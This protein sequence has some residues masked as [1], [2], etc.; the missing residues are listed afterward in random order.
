MNKKSLNLITETNYKEKFLRKFIKNKNKSDTKDTNKNTNYNNLKFKNKNIPPKKEDILLAKSKTLFNMNKIFFNI[1]QYNSKEKDYFIN[2]SQLIDILRHGNI[3]NP[4]II[5]INQTDIIL[6]KIFPHKTKFNFTEFMN[7][8]TELCHELYKDK[9]EKFPKDTM[10]NFL[11]CLYN[12]YKE[13]IIE[14][15]MTNFMETIEDNNCT[16]KSIETIISSKLERP[17]IKLILTLYDNLVEVYRVY[18]PNELVKYKSIN[19][20]RLFSESSQNLFKFCKD[21]ELYP[22]IINK[23]NLTMYYNLLMKYLKQKSYINM[24]IISFAENRKCKNLGICFKFSSFVL[25]LYHLCIFDYYKGLKFQT[26]GNCSTNESIQ[27]DESLIDV[28]KIVYFFKQ[29]ENSTGIKQFLLERARTNEKKYNFIFKK[30]DINI[31]KK[32]MDIPCNDNNEDEKKF[33]TINSLN[34]D[35]VYKILKLNKKTIESSPYTSVQLSERKIETEI[36]DEKNNSLLLTNA[37]NIFNNNN[38]NKYFL[39]MNKKDNY[40][41]SLSDLDEVLSVSSV[42]KEE[43]INK[44]EKLSEIF[45]RYSK[46][47]SKLEYNRMSYSSFLKFLSDAKLL[48]KVPTKNKIKYRRISSNLMVKTYTVAGIKQFER[49]LKYSISCDNIVLT[50]EEIKYKKYISKLVDTFRSTKINNKDKIKMT[51][52]S[53]I[54]STVT[55]S[56]NYPSYFSGI[57]KQLNIKDEFYYKYMNDFI[58][59]TD[60]FEPKKNANEEKYIP[61]K[62]NFA[63]FIKSFE[64]IASKLYPKILLDDAVSTFLTLKIDPFIIRIRKHTYKNT[65]IQKAMDKMEK[66]EIEKVLGKLGNIIYPFFIKFADNNKQMLFYQFF[67]VY[68]NLG[69][70][71][72]MISLTQM[73]K[74]FY[75][76]CDNNLDD[77]S[78]LQKDK[79]MNDKITFD[80]FIIS[81][82]IS[83]MLFNFSNIVSDTDRILYIYYFILESKFFK[84]INAKKNITKKIYKNL[85]FRNDRK[86]RQNSSVEISTNRKMRLNYDYKANKYKC[87]RK[88]IKRYN[89]FD[90]Y[91]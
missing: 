63:L 3:I 2:K 55:G 7:Y 4:E 86:L 46:I 34:N 74:I 17:I 36:N 31:A 58:R 82:G 87:D 72:E 78:T 13:I 75:I 61:N 20:V 81:L 62:M 41:I 18:F 53:L 9:F 16:L 23:V 26:L 69:L 51:E 66:P 90:I 40:L 35:H 60:S 30:K 5:S 54:F 45:L 91:K 6:S 65:E 27:Y 48:L 44:I 24:I 70:F 1:A 39:N 25:S 57:K 32:E 19:E 43:I 76:L 64:L 85:K 29:L 28:D 56:Y 83:S 47:Y 79:N 80:E 38:F 15:N 50:K 8:L 59:K 68:K 21:F 89:F 77:Y 14:K 84:N 22:S 49:D 11:T 88:I 71:P 52:A 73:K 37:K 12:N 10:D 67:D 42:V 33:N